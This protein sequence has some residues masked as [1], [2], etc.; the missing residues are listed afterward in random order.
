MPPIHNEII[1][2]I[3]PGASGGLAMLYRGKSYAVSMPKTERDV[4]D[5]FNHKVAFYGSSSVNLSLFAVIE[6]V[7]GYIGEAQPGSSAFKFGHSYGGL[8]MA[9][10]A[11]GIPFEEV[12]PQK[13]QKALGIATRNS[14]KGETKTQFKNRLK[15][16]AQSL[17]P[18]EEITL[19]TADALLIAEF[20]R[21]LRLGKNA[22]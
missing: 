12:T 14:K 18:K 5:Y 20:A 8:R 15:A 9:L 19:A 10:V 1:L 22:V 17:F 21:R 6:K 4:W 7:S 13:W 11:A 2:G 3:D 16:K